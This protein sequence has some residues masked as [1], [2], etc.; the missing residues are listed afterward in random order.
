M[1]I[2]TIAKLQTIFYV[3]V[4]M[5]ANMYNKKMICIFV[6]PLTLPDSCGYQTYTYICTN[7]Y[8]MYLL[9]NVTVNDRI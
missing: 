1:T 7:L 5:I 8:Y 3:F 2:T 4:I 9:T 6:V